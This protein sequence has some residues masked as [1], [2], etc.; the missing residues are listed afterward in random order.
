LITDFP[1][2]REWA[3][4]FIL[5]ASFTDFL[6]GYLARKLHQVTDLGKIID[7]L[8]DKIGI[9]IIALCLVIIQDI[10]LWYFVLVLARDAII[11]LGGVYIK[12]QKR[13]VPQ[14]NMAGKIAVN[15]IALALLFSIFNTPMARLIYTFLLWLS[16][17]SMTISL[18]IY[19]KRLFI[20]RMVR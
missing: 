19:A 8:A 2:H 3:V 11:F 13:V 12:Q 5:I 1:L 10:P 17:L 15:I 9:G 18:V 16:I 20:G 6:D 14:S 4:F 7:P